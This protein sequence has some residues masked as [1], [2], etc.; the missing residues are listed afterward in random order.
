MGGSCFFEAANESAAVWLVLVALRR[1]VSRR[2]CGW[3]FFPWDGQ[4]LGGGVV[5]ACFDEADSESPAVLLVLVLLRRPE[6]GRR[7]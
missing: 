6:S 7:C 3:F 5:G 4:S 1:P 2:W